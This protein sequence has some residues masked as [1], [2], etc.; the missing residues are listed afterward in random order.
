M[1]ADSLKKWLLIA[2]NNVKDLSENVKFT[3][4]KATLCHWH[5]DFSGTD[6]GESNLSLN[7]NL[8]LSG[9]LVTIICIT[10]VE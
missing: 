3:N 6:S 1:T 4:G 7:S 2:P 8:K 10:I 9:Y 5:I